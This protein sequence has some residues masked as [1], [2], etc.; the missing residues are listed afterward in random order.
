MINLYLT[1]QP[2]HR[3]IIYVLAVE[4]QCCVLTRL[5]SHSKFRAFSTLRYYLLTFLLSTPKRSTGVAWTDNTTPRQ[6]YFKNQSCQN[7][8]DTANLCVIWT[9]VCVKN[10]WCAVVRFLTQMCVI[11]LIL[12]LLSKITTFKRLFLL[13]FEKNL[14]VQKSVKN[15]GIKMA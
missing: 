10:Y 2:L 8:R 14:T 6:P 11:W 9:L 5:S 3:F 1:L 7:V 15:C 12:N 13:D 4:Q